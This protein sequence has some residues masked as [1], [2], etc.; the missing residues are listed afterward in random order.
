MCQYT[1]SKPASVQTLAFTHMYG[2]KNFQVCFNTTVH[3]VHRYARRSFA[4]VHVGI[5]NGV[6][7]VEYLCLNGLLCGQKLCNTSN[8]SGNT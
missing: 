3:C 8:Y 5:F 7:A 6:H 2:I 1:L 4:G